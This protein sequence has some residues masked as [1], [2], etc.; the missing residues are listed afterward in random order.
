MVQE[1]GI[2]HIEFTDSTFNI[3]LQHAKAVL[4]AIADKDLNLRCRA[5]GLNPSAVDQELVNLMKRVGFQDVD[6]GVESGCNRTLRSLGKNFNTE[7][8]RKAGKLLQQANIPTSWFLLMGAPGETADTLRETVEMVA[9]AASPWDL[10]VIGVG[11]RVYKGAPL[12]TALPQTDRDAVTDNF[13]HPVHFEPEAIDIKT[14]RKIAKH[15]YRSY[16]NFLIYNDKS[17]Y[18]EVVLKLVSAFLKVFFPEQPIWRVYIF[19]RRILKKVGVHKNY[20]AQKGH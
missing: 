13:L 20:P 7:D 16:P 3:P 2:H 12:I 1:T 8:I 9:R 5:L 19:V 10:V 11:I 14:I 17:G 18:P 4:R 15:A 6:L